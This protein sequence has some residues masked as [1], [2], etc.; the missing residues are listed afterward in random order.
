MS[1]IWEI[2]E[3]TRS[4]QMFPPILVYAKAH[5]YQ[6]LALGEFVWMHCVEFFILNLLKRYYQ[7]TAKTQLF[8]PQACLCYNVWTHFTLQPCLN[9][10]PSQYKC[11]I[12]FYQ[13]FCCNLAC[14][15][16]SLCFTMFELILRYSLVCK[17]F[18]HSI[19]VW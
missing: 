18:L 19:S 16:Y 6:C 1:K 13:L 17:L 9:S 3:K 11:M 4:F 15:P 10:L 8:A 5:W 7:N 14:L 2:Q 12:G